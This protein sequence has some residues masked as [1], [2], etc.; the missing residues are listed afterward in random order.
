MEVE[1]VLNFLHS[2]KGL[3]DGVVLSGGEATVYKDIIQFAH[4]IKSIDNF[5][6]KLDTNGTRPDIVKSMIDQN[7]V[8]YIAL[9]YKAPECKYKKVTGT[10]YY[11]PF[12]ELLSFLCSSKNTIPFEVRTTVHTSLLDEEDLSSIINDLDNCGYKDTFYI[13]NY[14]HRNHKTLG[15]MEDQKRLL[16]IEKIPDPRNFNLEFR[17]FK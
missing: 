6:I 14:F 1:D 7:L 11:K 9:D 3:L 8:D 2:R 16:N 13:Q 5:D 17:N 10:E 12:K 4:D 15:A